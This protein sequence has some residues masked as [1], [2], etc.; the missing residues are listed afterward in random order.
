[1][2]TIN[3]FK[4]DNEDRIKREGAQGLQKRY[5]NKTTFRHNTGDQINLLPYLTNPS[6]DTFSEDFRTF[7]GI[8]GEIFRIVDSRDNITANFDTD[9]AYKDHLKNTILEHAIQVVETDCPAD[10]KNLLSKLFLMKKMD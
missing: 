8:V 9:L 10:L 2:G 6:G 7:H 4:V 3:L 5:F 1:M